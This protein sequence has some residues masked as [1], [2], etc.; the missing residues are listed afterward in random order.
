MSITQ[1][2]SRQLAELSTRQSKP[3]SYSR[4]RT[5]LSTWSSPLEL[6]SSWSTS[7]VAYRCVASI[8]Q[9]ASSVP[10]IVEDAAGVEHGEH[11]LVA[12][13]RNPNP[14]LSSRVLSEWLWAR[15]ETR[16]EAFVYVDRGPDGT[17]RASE[18][19]P[20]FNPVQPVVA[21]RGSAG[22]LV[23]FAVRAESGGSIGLL[24][25]EVLW[26]RYP[27]PDDPWGALSPLAAAAHAVDLDE[28]ARE[29][30]RGEFRNGARPSN[31]VWL[32]DLD[33]DKAEQVVNDWRANISGPGNAGKTLFVAS[34]VVGKVDRLTM[35]PA[36]MGWLDTRRVS[37]EEVMLAHGVPKDYLLGGA[38]Y[39]NRAA[40]RATLWTDTIIPKLTLVASELTRQMVPEPGWVARFDTGDVDALQESEDARFAR[41][42]DAA[43]VDVL[44]LDELRALLG[45]DPLPSGLGQLTLTAYRQLLNVQANVAVAQ[46]QGEQSAAAL[47]TAPQ[48]ADVQQLLGVSTPES[49]DDRS[50]RRT[51]QVLDKLDELTAGDELVDRVAA[52]PEADV[53]HE[54]DVHVAKGERV[55]QRIAARQESATLTNLERLFGGRSAKARGWLTRTHELAAE[56]E[57][58]RQDQSSRAPSLE[59]ELRAQIDELFDYGYWQGYTREEMSS[60]IQAVYEAG[61]LRTA[62]AL[63]ISFTTFDPAVLDLME[64]RLDVLSGQVTATTQRIL[65]D[66]ILLE[67]V[68]RGESIDD[69]AA[70]LRAAFAD[71][72]TRRAEMIARTETVGGFNA[73]SQ[74]TA[75]SSGQCKGRIWRAT[76]DARTRE[77][78][79]EQSGYR[80]DGFGGTYP[81]GCRHPGD[82]SALPEETIQCRCYEEYVLK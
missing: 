11:E 82:P 16:G 81:N 26:L 49:Q 46:Q 73:A 33:D 34:Q 36:E 58:Q 54:Y 56:W 20:I 18:L 45:Y 70:R 80:I 9:N 39:E 29:W 68:A 60:W 27:H 72:S 7:S 50:D 77:T 22:E 31:A 32:G 65:E 76:T 75:R 37:A 53:L 67:G 23:G 42:K 47:D 13:W 14:L 1:R 19:W 5:P 62:G 10:L 44:M 55:V 2:L 35:S 57:R 61:Q 69:L 38:T 74:Q 52:V 79:A 64:Q 59:L 6:S 63:G 3:V 17:S 24:P 4:Y 40:S 78:H 12:L 30:Q 21:E 15:L 71:L 66:S 51:A 41:V 28:Y 8:S 43:V 48:R 25:A